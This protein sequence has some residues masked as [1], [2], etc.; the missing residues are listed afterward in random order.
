MDIRTLNAPPLVPA[1]GLR[2]AAPVGQTVGEIVKLVTLRTGRKPFTP[3]GGS[4]NIQR[5]GGGGGESRSPSLFLTT[6]A[7]PEPSHREWE[8]SQEGK[9]QLFS[10]RTR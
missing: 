2:K 5:G 9:K 8:T 4:G 10:Q 3:R 7:L 6:L 1:R